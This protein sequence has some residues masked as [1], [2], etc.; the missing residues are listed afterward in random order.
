MSVCRLGIYEFH[1]ISQGNMVLPAYKGSTL[2]GGFGRVFKSLACVTPQSC[3]NS[4][5]TGSRCPYGYV[6]ETPVP[7]DSA[8]MKKYPYAP[9]PFIIEPPLETKAQYSEN[10]KLRF[11]L[12]LFG[13]ACDYLPYFVYTFEELGKIGIGKAQCPY[14]VEKVNRIGL[15]GSINLIYDAQDRLL[16]PGSKA[17]TF[18]LFDETGSLN[19]SGQLTLT[20]LTPARIQVG[21]TLS[22]G[23]DFHEIVR[24]LLRRISLM[25]YFHEEIDLEGQ[26]DFREMIQAAT[27]IQTLSRNFRRYNWQ[28]YSNRQERHISMDG[29]M[30]QGIYQGDIGRF[31]RL[32]RLGEYLHI[33]KGTSF[34]L[35]QY[36]L[37]WQPST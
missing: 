27:S 7:E 31:I 37:V 35:G 33:G 25:M 36:R 10:E 18:N 34:G 21:N 26:V 9:H 19:P 14:R 11:R 8:R 13:K 1:L 5:K 30:G 16:Q 20:L 29:L 3:K 32:L 24:S 2:R 6:F 15:N 22:N 4:C 28:R 12:I 23:P 17:D